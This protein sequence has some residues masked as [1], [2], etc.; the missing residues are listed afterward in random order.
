MAHACLVEAF[1][2]KHIYKRCVVLLVK[3]LLHPNVLNN[4]YPPHFPVE[5]HY[6]IPRVHSRE[7]SVSLPHALS[8]M[9]L[10]STVG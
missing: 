3:L 4:L 8:N 5:L 9:S 2:V 7:E 6:I 10:L 1:F